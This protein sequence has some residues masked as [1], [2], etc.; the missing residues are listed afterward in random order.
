MKPECLIKGIILFIITF[1][2][3]IV[4]SFFAGY[5]V[6]TALPFANF[7]FIPYQGSNPTILN[8]LAMLATIAYYFYIL[9]FKIRHK[10]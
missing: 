1:P 3:A 7:N 9:F 8:W 4:F 6:G 5:M 2:A 10:N